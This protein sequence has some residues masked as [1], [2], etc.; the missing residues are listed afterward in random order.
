MR[1]RRCSTSTHQEASSGIDESS[2]ISER[3]ESSR[4]GR[5]TSVTTSSTSSDGRVA[6]SRLLGEPARLLEV[7]VD[8][9]VLAA[10]EDDLE[11]AAVDRLLR[12]PAVDD[13]P[14]LADERDGLPV[15]HARRPVERGLDERR[16]RR[17]QASR[18]TTS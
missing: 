1:P 14:L 7:A 15:D 13:A 10:L 18:G 3:R 8:T 12:P 16:P 11:V 6:T 2:A 17:V 5:S 9:D 4:T